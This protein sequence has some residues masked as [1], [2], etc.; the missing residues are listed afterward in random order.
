MF[1][2][3]DETLSLVFDILRQLRPHQLSRVQIQRGEFIAFINLLVF[4][5][6]SESSSEFRKRKEET[7]ILGNKVC[8]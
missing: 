5:T 2:Y 6:L 4:E 8:V 3:P 7:V 1:G